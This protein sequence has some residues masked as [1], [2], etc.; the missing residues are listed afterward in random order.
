MK[1]KGKGISHPGTQIGCKG[2]VDRREAQKD[3]QKKKKV[4]QMKSLPASSG[5]ELKHA[6]SP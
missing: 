2:T 1:T 6:T 3:I 5:I 4:K